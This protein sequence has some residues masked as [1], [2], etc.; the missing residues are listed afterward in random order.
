MDEV[1]DTH[2]ADG[3]VWGQPFPFSDLAHFIVPREFYWESIGGPGFVQ[4]KK[5]QNIEKLSQAL[6]AAG[7]PH[8]LT[9]LVLEIKCF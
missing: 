3:G 5:D 4:G 1:L 8:R 2:T 9:E 6:K 7:V